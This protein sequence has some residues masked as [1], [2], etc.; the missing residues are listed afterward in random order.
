MPLRDTICGDVAALSEMLRTAV[1]APVAS[2]LNVTETEQFA[3]ET[4][5]EPQVVVSAKS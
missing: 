2:G 3:P 1:A 4:R 5:L